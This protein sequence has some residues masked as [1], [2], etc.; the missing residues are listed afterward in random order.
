MELITILNLA[1]ATA[2]RDSFISTPDSPRTQDDRD[3]SATAQGF[4]SDLLALPSDCTRLT[5][6][7]RS[8]ALNHSPVGIF[9]LLCTP[10]GASTVAPGALWL[11]K[12]F[13]GETANAQ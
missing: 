9:R 7:S 1:A 6:D 8:G 11:S 4:G 5:T 12:K 2:S 3:L 13:P 10:W